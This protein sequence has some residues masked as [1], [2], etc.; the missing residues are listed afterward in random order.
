MRRF[1][2][3]RLSAILL[4][5]GT[6][7][8]SLALQSCSEKDNGESRI[9][10]GLTDITTTE[11]ESGKVTEEQKP[12]SR[13]QILAETSFLATEY[14]VDEIKNIEETAAGSFEV[15]KNEVFK[16][17]KNNDDPTEN[18]VINSPFHTLHI[19]GTEVPVY[20]ARCGKG[21]HSFAWVDITSEQEEFILE[22]T[23]V[24]S[25][26]AEKCVILPESRGVVGTMRGGKV[27]SE[28]TAEGSYTFTFAKNA[29][30]TCTD[31][32]LAPL[33]LMVSRAE[34]PVSGYDGQ[35]VEIEPGYHE[36]DELEFTRRN[37]LYLFKAGFHDVCSIRLPSNSILYLEKG[38]YLQ[39][40]DRKNS[41][42]S[43]N[44]ATAIRADDVHDVKIISRGLLDCGKLQGGEE[45]YKHVV[46]TARSV[47]VQISGLTIIN[48]NTWTICAY[49]AQRPLI[50]RNLLLSYRTYSDGIMMS[51]CTNGVGRYNFV[52]TGDDAIEFKGTGWGSQETRTGK[53]CV[54]EYND[55]WTD[56][57]AGYCLTWESGRPMDNMIFRNNSIGFA[58]PTWTARN[59]ALD[60]LLGTNSDTVW[61]NIIFENI[62]IYRVISP[63]AINV[64][65]QGD[66]AR[67]ENVT[68][69]NITVTHADDGV[70][71]FRM[72]FSAT[73]GGISGILLDNVSFRKK[74][75]TSD[76]ISDRSLFCNEASEYF[77]EL[78]VR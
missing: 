18:A 2:L 56:K 31:P 69:R 70:Y 41:D 44:T 19:N 75:L 29:N 30:D 48:S 28:I 17:G 55:L 25:E 47:N 36:N 4:I 32:T 42:G 54:Y 39:V 72:H 1:Y 43:Y 20:T 46:N 6:L 78:S 23:L 71:A 16:G 35:I 64:Q 74:K 76:D 24:L 53:G 61:S 5:T 40:T 65:I 10:S 67:L 12:K 57:G 38:A 21:A 9:P 34:N 22:L 26:R 8:Y 14:N 51:D 77:G 59:T 3:K 15:W 33:T 49:G 11:K 73:G 62:E 60:C 50:E 37:T 66:G 45:K 7:M 58:Q 63:N 27:S 68:F 52:R 13:A